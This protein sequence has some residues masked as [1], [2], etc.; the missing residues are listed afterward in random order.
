MHQPLSMP[1]LFSG[2]LSLQNKEINKLEMQ[3]LDITARTQYHLRTA[4]GRGPCPQLESISPLLDS[5]ARWASNLGLSYVC[6]V[7][8]MFRLVSRLQFI[9]LGFLACEKADCGLSMC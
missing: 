4:S 7:F 6:L 9:Q 5:T 1:G 2:G 3:R 8:E